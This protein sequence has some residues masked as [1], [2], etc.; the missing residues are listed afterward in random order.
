M[1][2]GKEQRSPRM[3]TDE[4]GSARIPICFAF[5]RSALISGDEVVVCHLPFTI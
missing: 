3:Y 4:H 1:E 2:N 5:S